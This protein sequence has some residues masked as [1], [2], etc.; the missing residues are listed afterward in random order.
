M[1]H[2]TVY[3]TASI[4]DGAAET[5]NPYDVRYSVSGGV[6]AENAPRT[7]TRHVSLMQP[8]LTLVDNHS[9]RTGVSGGVLVVKRMMRP[10]RIVQI[11]RTIY[12]CSPFVLCFVTNLIVRCISGVQRVANSWTVVR[13]AF[14][15]IRC[16][17]HPNYCHC[18]AVEYA[19]VRDAASEGGVVVVGR[20]AR[21]DYREVTH[22]V[23]DAGGETRAV[24]RN[25][26]PEVEHAAKLLFPLHVRAAGV[27]LYFAMKQWPLTASVRLA[28]VRTHATIWQSANRPRK[29][30]CEWAVNDVSLKCFSP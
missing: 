3:H 30:C 14:S 13:P 11:L 10:L 17:S 6:R 25:V 8:R 7:N 23:D 18:A 21:F 24:S 5:V 20:R 4:T 27:V 19:D 26:V 1:I 2:S 15:S 9:Q 28:M 29:R 22:D 16:E 12:C